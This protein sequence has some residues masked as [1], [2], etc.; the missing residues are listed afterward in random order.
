MSEFCYKLRAAVPRKVLV[1]L[2]KREK[3]TGTISEI[4]RKVLQ[5]CFVHADAV[6]E[7]ID[8]A[9]IQ[10]L[11]AGHGVLAGAPVRGDF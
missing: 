8:N 10:M 5:F 6:C 1:E 11:Y 7:M 3:K 2:K 9:Y 4:L